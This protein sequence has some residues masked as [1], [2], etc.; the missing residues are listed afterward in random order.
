MPSLRWEISAPALR[1]LCWISD[2]CLKVPEELG[3]RGSPSPLQ[4]TGPRWPDSWA[5]IMHQ[6]CMCVGLGPK[7]PLPTDSYPLGLRLLRVLVP[8]YLAGSWVS[9]CGDLRRLAG[10][11]IPATSGVNTRM[12]YP[13]PLP[14]SPQSSCVRGQPLYLWQLS[15]VS[16][17]LALLSLPFPSSWLSISHPPGSVPC[18]AWAVILPHSMSGMY[19]P[20]APSLPKVA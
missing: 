12:M 3:P 20:G 10:S 13:W 1:F 15:I 19:M 11:V 7:P 14:G 4:F 8:I 18:T 6:L 5:P 9:R 2:W 17:H 16:S